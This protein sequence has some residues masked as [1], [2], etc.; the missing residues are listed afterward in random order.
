MKAGFL[1]SIE[2]YILLQAFQVVRK[3]IKTMNLQ[4]GSHFFG[5]NCV[6]SNCGANIYE[7][8]SAWESMQCRDKQAFLL[9][10]M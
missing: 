2:I 7:A 9:G 8:T 4:I 5:K 10:F 1:K 6:I 3:W